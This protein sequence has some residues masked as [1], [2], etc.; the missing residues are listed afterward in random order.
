MEGEELVL[1]AEPLLWTHQ[2]GLCSPMHSSRG[3]VWRPHWA[4]KYVKR[5]TIS[6]YFQSQMEANILVPLSLK[7]LLISRLLGSQFHQKCQFHKA[8]VYSVLLWYVPVFPVTYIN[9]R[10]LPQQ[11]TL[12][13]YVPFIFLTHRS[14]SFNDSPENWKWKGRLLPV[15]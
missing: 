13:P 10:H 9:L 1:V 11:Q 15:S 7:K 12:T 5:K 8:I 14:F 6:T 3:A 2:W 4:P